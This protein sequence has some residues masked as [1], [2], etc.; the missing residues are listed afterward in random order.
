MDVS[1]PIGHLCML[2]CSTPNVSPQSVCVSVVLVC[3]EIHTVY[4][5]EMYI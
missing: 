1:T 3:A 2:L 4:Q 5:S